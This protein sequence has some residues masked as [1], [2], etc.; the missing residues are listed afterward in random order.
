MN[1]NLGKLGNQSNSRKCTLASIS[2]S[3]QREEVNSKPTYIFDSV[4]SNEEVAQ[5]V[6]E[7]IDRNNKIR[8]C[9]RLG[10]PLESVDDISWDRLILIA[11]SNKKEPQQK[12][13]GKFLEKI[14][15]K[16]V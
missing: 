6:M 2:S 13:K 12:R 16:G 15:G 1:K 7:E 11:L 3:P 5:E 9:E 14:K 4:F 8:L 10:I